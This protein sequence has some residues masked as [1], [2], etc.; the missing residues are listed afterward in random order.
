MLRGAAL[1]LL[2][3]FTARADTQPLVIGNLLVYHTA[4]TVNVV[5]L[6]DR[7]ALE[8]SGRIPIT[9]GK[10]IHA[11]TSFHDHIILL[12]WDDVEI[13]SLVD[14]T[15]PKPVAA[16][17][18]RTQTTLKSG[19]PRIEPIAERKFLIIS[20]AGAAELTVDPDGNRW[21]LTDIDLTPAL[22]QKAQTATPE[23]EAARAALVADRDSGRPRVLKESARFRYERFWTRRTKPGVITHSEYLRKVD[24]ARGKT[25][26]QLLLGEEVETID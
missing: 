11:Q 12:L 3:S 17:Q 20:P 5:P 15:S 16:F 18:L 7:A 21:A 23:S 25:V 8:V 22:R 10:A 19:H 1:L 9:S 13:Y 6:D 4:R 26:S 24:K 14:P 2:A